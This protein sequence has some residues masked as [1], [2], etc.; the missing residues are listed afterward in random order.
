MALWW[1]QNTTSWGFVV[2]VAVVPCWLVSQKHLVSHSRKWSAEPLGQPWMDGS[3]GTKKF[4]SRCCKHMPS[5]PTQF[6]EVARSKAAPRRI[7]KSLLKA[8]QK[9]GMLNRQTWLDGASGSFSFAGGKQKRSTRAGTGGGGGV[10]FRSSA[11][12]GLSAKPQQ[13]SKERE[14]GSPSVRRPARSAS[15]ASNDGGSR[16]ES[17]PPR[18]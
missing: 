12:S 17:T 15:A 9:R 18:P 2:G 8:Q 11:R 3:Q 5:P 1:L 14:T 10:E 13:S 16:E 7:K 4:G 6:N